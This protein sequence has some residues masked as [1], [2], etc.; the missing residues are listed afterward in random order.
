MLLTVVA[1][2]VFYFT[3]HHPFSFSPVDWGFLVLV[4]TLLFTG[5]AA[6]AAWRTV[7]AMKETAER[8][9]RA[10]V[11]INPVLLV[12]FGAPY[13]IRVECQTTNHGQTPAFQVNHVFQIGVLPNPLPGGFRF[14]VPD[15]VVANNS[16]I[17]PNSAIKSWFNHTVPLTGAEAAAIEVGTHNLHLWGVTSYVDAFGK[18]RTT[19]F[20]ASLDLPT[21]IHSR[22]E[23]RAGRNDPGFN[24]EYRDQHNQAT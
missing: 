15:R 17:F 2:S 16:A 8:Q 4:G 19:T 1:V 13:P 10:Y 21:F 3:A 22:N 23:L 14:P 18:S 5:A 11:S 7:R 6:V 9:L 24:W 12:N 20:N